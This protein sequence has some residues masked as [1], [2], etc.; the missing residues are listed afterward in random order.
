[1]T[2]NPQNKTLIVAPKSTSGNWIHE[3]NKCL[4]DW[5]IIHY[6]GSERQDLLTT[7]FPKQCLVM[8]YDILVR[9]IDSLMEHHYSTI[10]F[11]EAQ[12]LKNPQSSRV[13]SAKLLTADF[14][15][16][17]TGTPIENSLLDLWSIFSVLSPK[18]LGSWTQF[19]KRFAYPIEHGQTARLNDLKNLI[20]PLLLRRRKE[21]VV[22]DLP[23]KIEL[24][25]LV[26]LSTF[27]RDTYNQLRIQAKR[28]IQEN[29]QQAK[30]LVLSLLTKLRQ[31]C[32]HRKLVLDSASNHS[33]KL[34]RAL[35]IVQNLH[36]NKRKVL[37][38]SQFVRLLQLFK[39]QLIESEMDL[40]YLDG[41]T[42]SQQRQA[43]IDRFQTTDVSIFLIS[44]KAGG[45]GINLTKA[46][47]VIHLD[48]WWN[49]AV[50]DQ[51]SDRAHRIGQTQTVTVIR[52]VAEDSIETQILKLQEEKRRIASD[53]LSDS[54][55]KLSLEDITHL[56]D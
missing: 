20:Q 45:S 21:D 28:I 17:L 5:N 44:L 52:L 26:S 38:F 31:V 33:S 35:E 53:L 2:R 41:S 27:E 14:T 24:N 23:P 1:M 16:A 10:I 43:E 50:E 51:A 54:I 7:L 3:L 40:C 13:N 56:L 4:S 8:T 12:Y 55:S 11:D 46:T 32:C 36:Q 49:P 6:Q 9:D 25:E 19:K 37:V 18:H 22:F 15:I 34:D 48:P 39:E 30:F 47:E 42:S 29:P